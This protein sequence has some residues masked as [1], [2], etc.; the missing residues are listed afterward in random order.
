MG[1]ANKSW[2]KVWTIEPKSDTL[3]R[4]RI[5]TSRKNRTTDE[6]E[7]DFGGYVGFAGT[8]AAKKAAGLQEGDR[9]RLGDVTVTNRYDKERNIT[10]T[11]FNVFSFE[12]ADEVNG[13]NNNANNY[14]PATVDSGDMDDS[15]LPF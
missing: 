14:Q 9:I 10:Y 7:Q 13:G 8:A 12:T 11:N 6:Y 15:N 2:A 1:F 3:T 5:S 4:C